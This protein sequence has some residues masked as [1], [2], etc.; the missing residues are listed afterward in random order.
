MYIKC[1]YIHQNFFLKYEELQSNC[2]NC[3][4]SVISRNSKSE[5]KID[6][7]CLIQETIL[8]SP[9]V[10]ILSIFHSHHPPHF[11]LILRLDFLMSQGSCHSFRHYILMAIPKRRKS[12]QHEL[13]VMTHTCSPRLWYSAAG[14]SHQQPSKTLSHSTRGWRCSSVQRPCVK[15]PFLQKRTK[16]QTL[17]AL[18]L[19]L[20][21]T[22]L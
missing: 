5:V 18:F 6:Q 19:S 21:K 1:N 10:L 7:C 16:G 20:R 17:T 13:A 3:Q 15:P 8:M 14:R 11:S 2:L 9:I 12:G 4:T 22:F